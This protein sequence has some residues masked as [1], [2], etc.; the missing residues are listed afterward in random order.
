MVMKPTTPDAAKLGL[1][2][3]ASHHLVAEFKEGMEP[4]EDEDEDGLEI[5]QIHFF[6]EANGGEMRMSYHGYPKGYAQ[7]IESPNE[8]QVT[9]MQVRCLSI[10]WNTPEVANLPTTSLPSSE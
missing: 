7:V 9:P 10:I 4:D 1:A 6:S 3:G 8:F 5:P 2:H